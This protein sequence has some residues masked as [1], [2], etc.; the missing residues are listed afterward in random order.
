MVITDA[1]FNDLTR[2]E[3]FNIAAPF[4]QIFGA[5]AD[6]VLFQFAIDLLLRQRWIEIARCA[7]SDKNVGRAVGAIKT[8]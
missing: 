5:I 2:N 4:A 8:S 3:T 6:W 1:S 7:I